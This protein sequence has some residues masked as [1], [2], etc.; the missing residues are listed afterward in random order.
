[1]VTKHTPAQ[2]GLLVKQY[3]VFKEA[4]TC[5][6][7]HKHVGVAAIKYLVLCNIISDKI[8][9]LVSEASKSR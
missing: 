7:L 5:S 6:R 8:K 1:M 9:A 3:Q 2:N 4:S